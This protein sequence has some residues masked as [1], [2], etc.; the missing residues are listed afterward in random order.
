MEKRNFEQ[1]YAITFC[2]KL[3]MNVTKHTKKL[4]KH[5]MMILSCF[6]WHKM[7]SEGQETVKGEPRS[8]CSV[9]ARSNI[10]IERENGCVHRDRTLTARMIA[11]IL[12]KIWSHNVRNF[13]FCN[14][15]NKT[16]TYNRYLHK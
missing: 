11:F 10:N 14:V 5:S 9:F 8:G 15:S 2:L 16:S 12:N 3:K 13:S 4:E 1:F 7:F 6:R